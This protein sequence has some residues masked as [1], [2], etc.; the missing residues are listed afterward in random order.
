MYQCGA[1]AAQPGTVGAAGA[2]GG[3]GRSCSTEPS[4]SEAGILPSG[5]SGSAAPSSASCEPSGAPS[6]ALSAATESE[7]CA[8]TRVRPGSGLLP[9]SSTS[10]ASPLGST[11]T[12]KAP[13]G[14]GRCAGGAARRMPPFAIG[15]DSAAAGA[16]CRCP[17]SRA[18]R[19]I[20]PVKTNSLLPVPLRY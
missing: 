11:K 15:L 5:S 18:R 20:M 14:R 9:L 8:I 19:C 7:G 10:L 4:S 2:P 13:S 16:P 3:T 17:E 12:S 6:R 1:P